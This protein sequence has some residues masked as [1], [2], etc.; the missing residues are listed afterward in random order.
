MCIVA[1][2]TK[3]IGLSGV[4]LEEIQEGKYLWYITAN[5]SEMHCS[6]AAIVAQV[7]GVVAGLQANAVVKIMTGL[8]A[9]VLSRRC[10][11]GTCHTNVV[12]LT[13]RS[14][15]NPYFID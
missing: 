1:V 11:A 10:R 3:V 13:C 6:H 15:I 4:V 5:G 14:F 9:A 12:L 8:H 7:T 2:G